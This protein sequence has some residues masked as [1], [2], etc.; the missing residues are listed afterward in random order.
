[1]LARPCD[2]KKFEV[3]ISA[4]AIRVPCEISR[5]SP[6]RVKANP[7]CFMN[8]D[9]KAQYGFSAVG[10]MGLDPGEA[11]PPVICLLERQFRAHHEI[12]RVQRLS[13]KIGI[14]E[15]GGPPA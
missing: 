2:W 13:S 8:I 1:M 5:A 7:F 15:G 3:K 9:L 11:G 4:L 12:N 14:G 10:S 6:E